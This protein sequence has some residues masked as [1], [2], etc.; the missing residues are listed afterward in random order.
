MI[1]TA[2]LG[3][4]ELPL[5]PHQVDFGSLEWLPVLRSG[6]RSDVPTVSRQQMPSV[7]TLP[8]DICRQPLSTDTTA[9]VDAWVSSVN[10]ALSIENTLV[11]ENDDGTQAIFATYPSDPL[12][13]P[14]GALYV[15][16]T[17]YQKT[18]QIR[19]SP[20]ALDDEATI[21]DADLASPGGLD[22]SAIVTEYPARLTVTAAPTTGVADPIHGIWM[23]LHPDA[24]WTGYVMEAIAV[25][26]WD[27]EVADGTLGVNVVRFAAG[28]GSDAGT[29]DVTDFTES[30]YLVMGR[31]MVTNGGTLTVAPTPLPD[32]GALVTTGQTHYEWLPIGELYL[33]TKRVRGAA[34]S[35][36]TLTG[37]A[38]TQAA[39]CHRL[40]FLPLR[41]GWV[42]YHDT[43][44]PTDEISALRVEWEDVYVDDVV[45]LDNVLGGGLRATG[46]QLIVIAEDNDGDTVG[47]SVDLSAVYRPRRNWL[48]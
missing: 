36:L 38:A 33:P 16:A 2:T 11:I 18:A 14:A 3:A 44:G 7:R 25:T 23:A 46:G 10:K 43:D 47:L 34:T 29:I 32:S 30:A 42:S 40:A 4:I 5:S 13:P 1:L 26:G 8:L 31:F 12:P 35:T 19:V 9:T 45:E 22:L 20:F 37:S 6:G 39:Y 48:G 27:D 15:T 28:A 24:A 17:T 21:A 41:W